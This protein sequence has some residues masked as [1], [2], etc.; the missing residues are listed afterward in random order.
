MRSERVKSGIP[1]FDEL[2]NGGLLRGR[3][4]LVSGTSGAGKS[5]FCRQY[6]YKGAAEFGENGIL[7]TTEELPEDIREDSLAFG[8]D[9][10]KLEEENKIA[11]IDATSVKIGIPSKEKYVDLRPFDMRS[12]L[13]QI[14]SIQ[15]EIKAKRAVIDS[16]TAMAFSLDSLPKIRVEF[17][18]L[19]ATLNL[20]GMTS[21]LT[22]EIGD[23]K[24]LSRFGVEQFVVDG[25]IG[26]YYQRVENVRIRSIE[27]YKMRG[28]GHSTK[29]HPYDITENGIVVHPYE[30][31]FRPF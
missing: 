16:A 31:V 1:G 11:I 7:V 2:C 27:I 20:L 14:V 17:L 18:R 30:E 13:S 8:W 29:L 19:T 28:T 15:R 4:Y 3:S 25:V 6:L 26:M 9:F 12:L 24:S 23:E 21:L 5:I 10:E 22:C